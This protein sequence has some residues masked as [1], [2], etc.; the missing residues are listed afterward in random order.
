MLFRSP[1]LG[2]GAGL[3]IPRVEVFRTGWS[4]ETRTNEYQIA[5]P[6][7]QLLAGVEWRVTGRLSVF[8]EH[9]VTC[10]VNTG[11]LVG[12]GTLKTN[13]CSYQFLTGPALHLRSL[14]PVN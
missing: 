12:G 1:Y 3:S 14:N 10:S 9:K 11:L 13:L 8:L 5:G 6:A 4:K 7:F 2:I